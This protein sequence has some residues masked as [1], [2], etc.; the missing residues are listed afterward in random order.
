MA[1]DLTSKKWMKTFED[2]EERGL[3]YGVKHEKEEVREER[4]GR[5][6]GKG[7]SVI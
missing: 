7:E 1:F 6:G 3:K 5:G 4:G 2:D